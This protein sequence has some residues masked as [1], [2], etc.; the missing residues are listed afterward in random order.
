M[1][2]RYWRSWIIAAPL[3]DKL[4]HK[5]WWWIM[6]SWKTS[7]KTCSWL[8]MTQLQFHTSK[9]RHICKNLCASKSIKVYSFM[10][11]EKLY[12]LC[13]ISV[14]CFVF[15]FTKGIIINTVMDKNSF[16]SSL[17]NKDLAAYEPCRTNYQLYSDSSSDSEKMSQFC[18]LFSRRLLCPLLNPKC[19]R[20]H[21]LL[22]QRRQKMNPS[23][24]GNVP[25]CTT[26]IPQ[27]PSYSPQYFQ[28]MMRVEGRLVSYLSL[29]AR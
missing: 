8:I 10:Y 12:K 22:S 19:W 23:K 1:V 26:Y 20:A 25:H 16:L 3:T 4:L 14:F 9:Y 5:N 7:W 11:F 21:R 17:E 13:S 28:G 15:P 18:S 27:I 29:N 2:V 6:A 24:Q